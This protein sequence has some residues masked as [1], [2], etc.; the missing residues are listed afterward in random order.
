ML[1]HR[2][3]IY[4]CALSLF[5]LSGCASSPR[6]PL[7]VYDTDGFLLERT[8]Y[9][10]KGEIDTRWASVDD[11]TAIFQ[12]QEDNRLLIDTIRTE[13]LRTYGPIEPERTAVS[14]TR[15]ILSSGAKGLSSA[16]TGLKASLLGIA[17]YTDALKN[18]LTA[19]LTKAGVNEEAVQ[20]VDQ[21][22]SKAGKSASDVINALPDAIDTLT[23]IAVG[24]GYIRGIS[25]GFQ[26]TADF[27]M[28]IPAATKK[29]LGADYDALYNSFAKQL[30]DTKD[31][32]QHNA[33][34]DSLERLSRTGSEK[35]AQLPEYV[36]E[37]FESSL[38]IFNETLDSNFNELGID[39]TYRGIYV[40]A[41]VSG[42]LT[43]QLSMAKL[44][45][46]I[47]KNPKNIGKSAARAKIAARSDKLKALDRKGNRE[48]RLFL[49][50]REGHGGHWNKNK[51]V[52]KSDIP[53]V[54]AIT[55]GKGIH[56]TGKESQRT[57]D[58]SPWSRG[59]YKITGLTGKNEE[60]FPKLYAKIAARKNISVSKAEHWV[61]Q[62]G[63]TPHHVACN[64][65]LLVPTALHENIPHT[66]AASM[67]RNGTCK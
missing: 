29:I 5:L 3:Y 31:F 6:E 57:P 21:A 33:N 51:T 48:D 59:S 37:E 25:V 13:A 27:A 1:S 50:P 54:N 58:F 39:S 46:E 61:K 64:E 16:A 15:N 62:N 66:G 34:P 38:Q 35:I 53:E 28:A 49:L 45:Y 14:V 11:S 60:D 18:R 43:W 17:P 47:I 52:W 36:R 9:D 22:L 44:T 32:I 24:A 12:Y 2:L 65:L 19:Q 42:W 8:T 56:F 7:A 40:G 30:Y 67:L 63:L 41:F 20:A 4:L 10:E 26:E 55:G 23:V